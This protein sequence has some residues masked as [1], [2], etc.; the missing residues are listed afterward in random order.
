MLRFDKATYFSLL[1]IPI[2]VCFSGLLTDEQD[3]KA[4]SLKFAVHIL[5]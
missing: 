2:Q 1:F 5:Y 3:Q 4:P